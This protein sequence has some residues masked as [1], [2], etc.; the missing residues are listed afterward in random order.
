MS[1]PNRLLVFGLYEES[2]WRRGLS[3]CKRVNK[4]V[5]KRRERGLLY[6]RCSVVGVVF[7]ENR[8]RSDDRSRTLG[9]AIFNHNITCK[10][11]S[12]ASTLKNRRKTNELT[13]YF[14]WIQ[15]LEPTRTSDQL[16]ASEASVWIL[17]SQHAV[18]S[19]AH[20]LL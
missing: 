8:E 4:D 10:A 11:I 2:L 18:H 14:G 13:E 6:V 15:P 3:V 1:Q 7:P 16:I 20:A 5:K 17:Q 19:I 9:V 12:Q